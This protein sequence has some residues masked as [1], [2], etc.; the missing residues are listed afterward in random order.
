MGARE[1]GRSPN[2]EIFTKTF[3]PSFTQS[4]PM[5]EKANTIPYIEF[6]TQNFFGELHGMEISSSLRGYAGDR[7]H[8]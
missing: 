1:G 4:K 3:Y 8:C 5:A 2:P 7:E 6:F